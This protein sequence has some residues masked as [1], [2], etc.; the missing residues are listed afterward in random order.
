SVRVKPNPSPT[1]FTLNIHH[2]Y[3]DPLIFCIYD[4]T[5]RLIETI[6]LHTQH[7]EIALGH[8]YRPGVYI[9]EISC[10]RYKKQLKLV[11]TGN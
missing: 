4:M 8:H 11:K 3:K 9:A 1:H 7:I 5:G 2:I 10:G 6:R